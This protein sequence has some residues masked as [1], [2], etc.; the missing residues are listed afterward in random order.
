MSLF[1]QDVANQN[2]Y[3]SGASVSLAFPQNISAGNSII[4]LARSD[5]YST[6]IQALMQI[7][8]TQGNT[9]VQVG[10]IFQS[11][12]LTTLCWGYVKTIAAS[13]PC[14]VTATVVSGPTNPANCNYGG[15]YLQERAGIDQV[16]PFTAGESVASSNAYGGATDAT[17][18][19]LTPILAAQPAT[20]F[21]FADNNSAPNTP[22]AGTGFTQRQQSWNNGG[23]AFVM[24]PQ[25]RQLTSTAPVAATYTSIVG[26]DTIQVIAMVLKDS[27]TVGG[28]GPAAAAL[29]GGRVPMIGAGI[30]PRTA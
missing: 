25:D 9:Y 23:P 30:A 16:A 8:D 15:L 3:A 24:T 17:T 29:L 26:S 2:V 18:S 11:G 21:G 1:V 10:T 5:D 22:V 4:W 12:A 7:S 20:L 28:P 14:T 27:S 13:G 6:H 19:G